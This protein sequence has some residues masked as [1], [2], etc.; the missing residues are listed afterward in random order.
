MFCDSLNWGGGGGSFLGGNTA[1]LHDLRLSEIGFV[2][3]TNIPD[4]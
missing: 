1:V 3:V 2:V 4:Y